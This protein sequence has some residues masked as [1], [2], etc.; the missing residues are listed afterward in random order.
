MEQVPSGYR[1]T[2]ELTLQGVSGNKLTIW[3][4]RGQVINTFLLLVL[5]CPA[6]TEIEPIDLPN[7]LNNKTKYRKLGRGNA[8]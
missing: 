7:L 6:E 1:Y 8:T 5:K 4:L 2:Q 3:I